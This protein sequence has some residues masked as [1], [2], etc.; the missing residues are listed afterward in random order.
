MAKEKF[1]SKVIAEPAKYRIN[2]TG[3]TE[4]KIGKLLLRPGWNDITKE[5]HEQLINHPSVK[6][7]IEDGYWV[8]KEE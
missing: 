7:F 5:V 4:H 6:R 8:F 2:H 1:A 3:K